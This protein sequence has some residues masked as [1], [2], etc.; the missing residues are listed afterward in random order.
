MI[1]CKKC[2]EKLAYVDGELRC[3]VCRRV[4]NEIIV[5]DETLFCKDFSERFNALFAYEYHKL[6]VFL[7]DKQVYGAQLQ[8]KDIYEVLMK[9]PALLS[10]SYLFHHRKDEEGANKFLVAL[11]NQKNSMG[12]WLEH[13]T[14]LKKRLKEFEEVSTL[15]EI[16]KKTIAFCEDNNVVSWRNKNIGHGATRTLDDDN[17]YE[18]LFARIESITAFFGEIEPLYSRIRIAIENNGQRTEL[19]GY[20]R[21]FFPESGK[22][23]ADID[24]FSLSL[25]PFFYLVDDGIYF[26]DNYFAKKSYLDIVEYPRGKRQMRATHIF[27][28]LCDNSPYSSDAN[29]DV[30]SR[31]EIEISDNVLNVSDFVPPSFIY[32]W[33][34]ERIENEDHVF[35]IRLQK[36]MGKSTLVR[37]LDPFQMNCARLTGTSVR[38]Y[39]INSTYGSKFYSFAS[40]V[41]RQLSHDDNNLEFRGNFRY[42]REECDD[43]KEEFAAALN[44]AKRQPHLRGKNLLFI[45]DGIDELNPQ[46]KRNITDFIPD[47]DMLD[48]GVY[49]MLT[50]RTLLAEDAVI[51]SLRNLL[52]SLSSL[53]L[54]EVR[55]EDAGYKELKAKYFKRH[56]VA[57]LKELCKRRKV[58]FIYGEEQQSRFLNDIS[59]DNF[60]YLRQLKELSLIKATNLIDAGAKS[61]DCNAVLLSKNQTLLDDYFASLRSN[62]GDKYFRQFSRIMVTFALID[63][64]LTIEDLS[65]LVVNGNISLSFLGFINT[66]RMF[67]A[68]RRTNSGNSYKISHLDNFRYIR[69]H[70]GGEIL[71]MARE[72][73]E[74]IDLIV[75]DGVECFDKFDMTFMPYFLNIVRV[76]RDL[77]TAEEYKN[78]LALMHD[79]FMKQCILPISDNLD[80]Q[81]IE[82]NIMYQQSLLTYGQKH[83]LSGSKEEQLAMV[84]SLMICANFRFAQ[85]DGVPSLDDFDKAF[86]ILSKLELTDDERHEFYFANE[87]VYIFL[88]NDRKT[89]EDI[90]LYA[91][92]TEPMY[93]DMLSRGYP[94]P[95]KSRAYRAVIYSYYYQVTDCWEQSVPYC[96]EAVEYVENYTDVVGKWDCAERVSDA[97]KAYA[98]LCQFDKALEYLKRAEK[99]F[100]ECVKEGYQPYVKNLWYVHRRLFDCYQRMGDYESAFAHAQA[101]IEYLEEKERMNVLS[102]RVFIVSAYYDFCKLYYLKGDYDNCIKYLQEA[103]GKFNELDT[104]QQNKTTAL[105]V[106]KQISDMY[107]NLNEKGAYNGEN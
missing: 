55:V 40:E 57:P 81:L 79:L 62:Y 96:L 8:L 24:G 11:V 71:S 10:A 45:I 78:S 15:W 69:E 63:D 31:A 75:S 16:I 73:S 86:R 1:E 103:L 13:L 85:R 5:S 32:D 61:I 91:N 41:Y 28:D 51:Y 27:D 43:P 70:M 48:E 47:P 95:P 59:D 68:V 12:N 23:I 106:R 19:N 98:H 18:D 90:M 2:G 22:L 107:K 4:W 97:G 100:D 44:H 67:L 104:S 93:R 33:I 74:K 20:H 3:P 105:G 6:G 101:A 35:M 89:P 82:R 84:R 36:G 80:E 54:L 21:I 66:I 30:I 94:F 14:I 76:F 60:L 39:Y 37:A 52:Q 58:E 87:P 92:Y 25:E 65:Y 7:Q 34:E 64:Y 46:A 99:L 72:L 29:D 26:Y 56:I 50:S 9:F 53:P 83:C 102:N 17:L 77:G 38:T 49:V 42:M 88:L